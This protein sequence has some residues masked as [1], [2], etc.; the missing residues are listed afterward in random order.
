MKKGHRL[1]RRL[2]NKMETQGYIQSFV[3][4]VRRA[5]VSLTVPS[6]GDL[7]PMPLRHTQRTHIT[8]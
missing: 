1:W 5:Y 7:S 4:K 8:W 6:S 2:R 3:G